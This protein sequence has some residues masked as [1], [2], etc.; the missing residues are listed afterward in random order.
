MTIC[1][2]AV[3]ISTFLFH[4]DSGADEWENFKARYGNH[5][6]VRWNQKLGTLRLVYGQGIP[7]GNT[8]PISHNNVASY[9]NAFMATN[10]DLLRVAMTRYPAKKPKTHWR[11]LE[12]KISAVL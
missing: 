8:L 11:Q 4:N 9:A 1:L 5:F 3:V 7:L 10:K 2:V 12:R 6:I